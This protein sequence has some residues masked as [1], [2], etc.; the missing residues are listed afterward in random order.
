MHPERQNP[1]A[2]YEIKG[3]ARK[4]ILR[5]IGMGM[6][7][8]PVIV[9]YGGPASSIPRR[10]T[11]ILRYFAGD[12]QHVCAR[13]KEMEFK[14]WM[15]F[16]MYRLICN[17]DFTYGQ[18]GKPYSIPVEQLLRMATSISK[19]KKIALLKKN[20]IWNNQHPEDP[21]V[22]KKRE[23]FKIRVDTAVSES[24]KIFSEK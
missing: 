9:F 14:T 23:L 7:I 11:S 10:D 5:Q 24:L 22:I 13:L 21:V 8:F 12:K 17:Q 2:L 1:D 3:V 19:R 16:R 6:K 18:I 4:D 20:R 15:D